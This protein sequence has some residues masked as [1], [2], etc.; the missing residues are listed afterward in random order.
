MNPVSAASLNSHPLPREGGRGD[1]TPLCGRAANDGHTVAIIGGGPAGM[2]LALALH[3]QG[4]G[5]EIIEARDRSAI[6]RDAR[7]LALS[8]GSVQMLNWLGV[9]APLTEQGGATPIKTI[10]ISHRGGL[11]RTRMTAAELSVPALG[12]VVAAQTLIGVLDEHIS[13]AGIPYRDNTKVG[14]NDAATLLEQHAL[15]AW[16]EGAVDPRLAQQRDYGQHAVLCTATVDGSHDHVAWERFTEDGPVALLPQGPDYAVVFACAS[17]LLDEI[18]GES[19]SQ[20]LARL[21]SRFGQRLRL[22]GVSARSS[23][24][25]GLRWRDSPVAE[26]QVWLGNAAQTLHPVA[27]QGFNLALRDIWEF[28]RIAGTRSDL[29]APAVLR[30]YAARRELDRRGVIGFTDTLIDTF[31]TDFAP[32]RHARGAGLVALDL[33]PPL[34]RFVARRMMFGD[35]SW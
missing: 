30:D 34:R 2:A 10:H 19:D 17:T 26:R 6:Q 23:Y 21:Q 14:A 13:A 32:V 16:A 27:G 4:I 20:F 35:R 25:L 18:L 11:G 9:W 3:R 7:V 15:L 22:T 28:A 8:H 31:G 29:K 5:S 1:G 24:P 12:Q 33:L